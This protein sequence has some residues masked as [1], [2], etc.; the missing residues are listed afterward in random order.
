MTRHADIYET[1][2]KFFMKSRNILISRTIL[3]ALEKE[4]TKMWGKNKQNV[5]GFQVLTAVTMK[6]TLFGDVTTEYSRNDCLLLLGYKRSHLKRQCP[7]SKTFV[8]RKNSISNY[9]Q[10]G[11]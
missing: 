3:Q 7:S 6:S 4:L 5:I 8:K 1:V 10:L 9:T 2:C 11:H